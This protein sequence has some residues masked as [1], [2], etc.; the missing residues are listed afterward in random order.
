MTIATSARAAALGALILLPALLVGC[1]TAAPDVDEPVPG[2]TS[3]PPAGGGADDLDYGIFFEPAMLDEWAGQ[4]DAL[5]AATEDW[6]ASCEPADTSDPNGDCNLDLQ[7]LLRDV[8]D[9]KQTWQTFD[10]SE[11]DDTSLSGMVALKPTRD[12]TIAASE[13]GGAWSGDCAYAEGGD[14]CIE[15]AGAFVGDLETLNT[16]FAAWPY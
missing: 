13:S 4:R 11:W 15:A 14:D 6:N 1:A 16:E 2:E 12:A 7:Q 3:A 5:A 9:L 8:N 10:N